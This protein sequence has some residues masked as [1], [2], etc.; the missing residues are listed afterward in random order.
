M[1]EE[2][3]LH[4]GVVHPEDESLPF[5]GSHVTNLS[6]RLAVEGGL[7]EDQHDRRRAVDGGRVRE[8]VLSDDA[9]DFDICGCEGIAN[10]LGPV[11]VEEGL[12]AK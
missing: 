3:V 4:L 8:L 9:K 12:L 1:Q 2:V 5:D 7:V 11:M 6:P 10:E